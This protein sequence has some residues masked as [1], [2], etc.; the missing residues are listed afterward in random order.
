MV[1][2]CPEDMVEHR[3]EISELIESMDAGREHYVYTVYIGADYLKLRQLDDS[4]RVFRGT[5]RTVYEEEFPAR[6]CVKQCEKYVAELKKL[7]AEFINNGISWHTVCAPYIYKMY[8]VFITE[9]GCPNEEEIAEI[10][11][12]FEEYASE[13]EYDRV[14]IW[15]IN[16]LEIKTSSYPDFALDNIH[17]LHVIYES[18]LDV[19]KDYLVAGNIPLWD[20][21]MINGELRIQCD[22]NA[23]VNWILR[24]FSYEKGMITSGY[25]QFHNTG[26]ALSKPIHT[27]AEAKCFVSSLGYDNYLKLT[28]IRPENKI[29][30]DESYD[31]D[32]FLLEEIRHRKGEEKLQ[33]IFEPVEPGNVFNRD[34]MSYLVSRL[35]LI[36]P[37]YLCRGILK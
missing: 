6:F 17:Y 18:R 15:N 37:E 34:I 16:T 26:G 21:S 13:V 25:Q 8:D 1:P 2:M 35:Q 12:D 30:R 14:P 3:V 7:Y 32:A 9:T 20:V 31:M 19:K 11:V 4:P 23:P 33:F 5:I 10:N 28:D 22:E 27:I 29:S 24:E 36:Y